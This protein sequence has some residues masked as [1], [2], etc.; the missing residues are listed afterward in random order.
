MLDARIASALNKII[1][2]SHFKTKVSLEEQRAQKEDRFLRGSQIAYMIYDFF[3]SQEPTIL[4]NHAD[5]LTVVLRNDDIQELDSKWDEILLSMT[6][7]HL[8]T[9]WKVCTNWEYVSLRNSK[10]CWNCTIWRFIRRKLDL[11]ITDWRK[12]KKSI[13]QNLRMKSP[14]AKNG[15]YETNAVVKNQGTKQRE[16]RSLG[17]CWQW[18]ANGQC[19]KGDNCSFRHGT[20]MRAKATQPNPSPR[21]STQQSVRHASRTKSPRSRSTSGKMARLPCKDYLKGTCTTPFCEKWHPPECLFYKSESGCRVG[22][23]C[24]YAHRQVDEQPSKR[25]KKEWW[26]KCSGHVENYTTIGLRISRYGAAEIFI[27]FAGRAQTCW[28]QSDV[29]DSLKPWY[30]TPAFETR[31]HR[32]EWVAKVIL[33]SVT[34]MLQN[35]RIGLKKRR[36]GKS[37]VPVKQ[38][39]NWRKISKN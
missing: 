3:R 22:E 32:L 29:F 12:W 25:S 21:S 16:Q 34:P 1:Q 9:S 26:Q 27:D 20:N 38:R 30:V 36:N 10:L 23:R 13:D 28:S 33:I 24:S 14:E 17:D 15:N 8:M 35:L 4:S 18:K 31:I 11:I 5:L 2:N 37:D 6:K 7:T 19:S 39:G